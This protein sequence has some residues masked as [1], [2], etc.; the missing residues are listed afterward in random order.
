MKKI[1][2]NWKNYQKFEKIEKI[3]L[4]KKSEKNRQKIEKNE[5]KKMGS[6]NDQKKW[7]K[8]TKKR[9]GVPKM[10]Q[11]L[12]KWLVSHFFSK[13]PKNWKTRSAN[14]KTYLN[15]NR[16]LEDRSGISKSLKNCKKCQKREN[17]YFW[18]FFHPP[19]PKKITFQGESSGKVNFF[20][21]F[22]KASK[23]FALFLNEIWIENLSKNRQKI[24]KNDKKIEIFT[25][26]KFIKKIK[27]IEKNWKKLKKLMKFIKNHK[28][29]KFIKKSYPMENAQ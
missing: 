26:K 14:Q 8:V 9:P 24:E 2:K 4:S 13:S 21:S 22:Q 11:K 23:N 1:D 10:L 18:P 19:E 12:S 5:W 20:G 16:N 27:K 28:I 25:K 7:K 29:C 17:T 3:Y 15:G 6:K